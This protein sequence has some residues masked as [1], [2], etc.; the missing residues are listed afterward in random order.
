[1]ATITRRSN[2]AAHELERPES[3]LANVWQDALVREGESVKRS[4]VLPVYNEEGSVAR[5]IAAVASEVTEWPDCEILVCDNASTDDT[6]A[7]VRGLAAADPR[8]SVL[9]AESNGL[10]AWNVGRGI[11]SAQGDRIFVL[12]GDGQYPPSVFRD[13]DRKLADGAGLVLG[14]RTVRV[15]GA[16]RVIASY[17]YLTLCR[18][19]LGFDLR[20][21]NAGARGLSRE[22]ASNVHIRHCGSM[23]NPE[24]YATAVSLGFAVHE[25]S[26]GHEHRIAGETSH[27]FGR[28]L[29]LIRQATEYFSFLRKSY[30]PLGRSRLTRRR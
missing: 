5:T 28:P 25:V 18:L 16:V 19:Y 8:I 22:F 2:V 6:V 21:I 11:N 1:M 14:H 12:D 13:L 26:V 9:T 30:S 7:I 23:V 17:T 27:V 4:V 10:Y 3:T 29:A 24:L 20:D 15:G